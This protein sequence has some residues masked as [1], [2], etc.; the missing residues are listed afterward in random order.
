MCG[1]AWED[2]WPCLLA[3]CS[4][5]LSLGAS[6]PTWGCPAP[7]VTVKKR[8]VSQSHTCPAPAFLDVSFLDES[9]HLLG[10][11]RVFW[12]RSSQSPQLLLYLTATCGLAWE[13]VG[14]GKWQT[15]QPLGLVGPLSSTH[16]LN[17]RERCSPWP[18]PF[19][20]LLVHFLWRSGGL[21]AWVRRGSQ[22]YFLGCDKR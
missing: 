14:R 9:A 5:T 16:W 4:E 6:S 2:P 1:I 8:P 20:Q 3:L 21:E 12:L 7:Q 18:F 15:Y 11:P 19:A 13:N 10:L 17:R 22:L